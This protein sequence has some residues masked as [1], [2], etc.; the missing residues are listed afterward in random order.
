MTEDGRQKACAFCPPS[1][2]FCRLE[3]GFPIRI[4][5]DQSL[6]AAPHGFSQRTTSFIACACQGIH[7]T[8]LR[9]LIALIINAR[10]FQDRL[11]GGS[12]RRDE[13][14][15]IQ[16][17]IA[18]QTMGPHDPS[19]PIA[20]AE[21]GP[22]KTSVTRELPVGGAVKPRQLSL[23]LPHRGADVRTTLLFTMSKAGNKRRRKSENRVQTPA[24][25]FRLPRSEFWLLISDLV[26]LPTAASACRSAQREAGGARR[27]RTDDLLL[28]K[29]ALSQLSY[30]P[31][32]G[33]IRRQMQSA[34]RR[35]RSLKW[36][37]WDRFERS[38][39]T[40][41]RGAL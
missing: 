3:V 34:I 27:D 12:V 40:L 24:N 21:T 30:G 39:L 23:V 38:D 14:N 9:H 10:P 29:Q 8:P 32:G 4:S 18:E 16:R 41:I 31:V 26:W 36:W 15:G 17:P 28:A 13:T 7:R 35:C 2:D 25:R 22:R 6:F 5:A 19:R 37:A 11:P 33:Q 20:R 1:S